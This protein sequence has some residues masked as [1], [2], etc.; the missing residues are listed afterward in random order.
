MYWHYCA[1]AGEGTDVEGSEVLSVTSVKVRFPGKNVS[2]GRVLG[3]IHGR[4][5]AVYG[6]SGLLPV[7]LSVLQ[8]IIML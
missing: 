7:A 4:L 8:K 2:L 6:V 1:L 5:T 3:N